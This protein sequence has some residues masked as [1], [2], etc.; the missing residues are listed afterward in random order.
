MQFSTEGIRITAQRNI[1]CIKRVQKTTGPACIKLHSAEH[2]H[3][4]AFL[5]LAG[6][7]CRMLRGTKASAGTEPSRAL[8]PHHSHSVGSSRLGVQCHPGEDL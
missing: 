2:T 1:R 8:G 6:D 5:G 4:Q 3:Q 7:H